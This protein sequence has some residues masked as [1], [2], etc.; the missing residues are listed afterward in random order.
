MFDI[1]CWLLGLAKGTLMESTMFPFS[2]TTWRCC[3][4]R[5]EKLVLRV[6]SPSTSNIVDARAIH[7]AQYGHFWRVLQLRQQLGSQ[8]EALRGV[9][10]ACSLHHL[11]EHLALVDGVH[12]LVDLVHHPEG[13]LG[14]LL[15]GDEVQHGADRPLTAALP[16]AAQQLQRLLLAELDPHAHLE[17]VK[18]LVLLQGQLAHT[19]N[20]SERLREGCVHSVHHLPQLGKPLVAHPSDLGLV[21]FQGGSILIERS[22]QLLDAFGALLV[23]SQGVRVPHNNGVHLQLT[24]R[25]ALVHLLN[26]SRHVP[27]LF[28]ER[29]VWKVGHLLGLELGLDC[30]LFRVLLEQLQLGHSGHEIAAVSFE[31][32]QL[33][34]QKLGLLLQLR[35][36]QRG[37]VQLELQAAHLRQHREERRHLCQTGLN[38]A[39]GSVVHASFVLFRGVGLKGLDG[40]PLLLDLA[41]ERVHFVL[42]VRPRP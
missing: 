41:G 27:K 32:F 24:V 36:R 16:V 37:R 9:W 2:K 12:A 35:P 21:T 5:F 34:F 22:L 4:R 29:W 30:L 42:K 6:R 13:A 31:F 7:N 18:V 39:R 11:C 1:H 20:F 23:H 26:G 14:E 10:S 33:L 3:I 25:D 17:L 40:D 38:N 28:L 8:Q 15:E 19:P